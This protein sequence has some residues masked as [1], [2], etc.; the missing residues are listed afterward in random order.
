MVVIMHRYCKNH[1]RLE[2]GFQD[3]GADV[4]AL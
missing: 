1:F 2:N 4:G 3:T